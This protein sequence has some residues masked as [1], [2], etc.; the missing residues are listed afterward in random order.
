MEERAIPQSEIS[1]VLGSRS[2]ASDLLSG[3]RSISK[4]QAQK[5]AAFF[6]VPIDLFL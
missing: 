6:R 3:R 4:T 5:L 2:Q 1:G